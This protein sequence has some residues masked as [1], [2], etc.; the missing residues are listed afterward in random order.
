MWYLFKVNNKDS[1]T[2]S[3]KCR[4]NYFIIFPFFNF[5]DVKLL[6]KGTIVRWCSPRVPLSRI[7]FLYRCNGNSYIYIPYVMLYSIVPLSATTQPPINEKFSAKTALEIFVFNLY[8][9]N[10][11]LVIIMSTMEQNCW[12]PIQYWILHHANFTYFWENDN[13]LVIQN[14]F[15]AVWQGPLWKCRTFNKKHFLTL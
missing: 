1:I 14:F 8:L 5:V 13:F 10:L 7:H 6:K 3:S 11:I 2:T 4:L 12:K 15:L 9:T